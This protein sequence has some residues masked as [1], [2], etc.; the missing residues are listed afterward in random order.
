LSIFYMPVARGAHVEGLAASAT[1]LV[2]LDQ[3]ETP[4]PFDG[5]AGW[6]EEHLGEPK[7]E[8]DGMTAA[9]FLTSA[10]GFLEETGARSVYDIWFDHSV[11]YRV[12]KDRE[13]EENLEEAK[14]KVAESIKT[15]NAH[16]KELGIWSHGT[17]NDF[18]L[19]FRLRFRRVHDAR[20]PPLVVEVKGNPIEL[21]DPTGHN[22]FELDDR[23]R[24]L[25]ESKSAVEKKNLQVGR[26][27]EKKLVWVQG[28][29]RQKFRVR[30]MERQMKIDVGSIW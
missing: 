17:N 9:D 27:F 23:L 22:Q 29:L 1:L 5:L 6:L 16:L 18:Y 3:P 28:I 14:A 15:S 10:F 2:Y 21:T 25:E 26:R 4:E 19:E 20:A 8:V 12:S 11:V 24:L 30:T 13:Q 7:K